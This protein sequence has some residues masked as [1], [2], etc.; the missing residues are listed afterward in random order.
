MRGVT[1]NQGNFSLSY[2]GYLNTEAKNRSG[3]GATSKEFYKADLMEAGFHTRI[4]S[5]KNSIK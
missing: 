3:S 5:E 2:Q 1:V 4:N